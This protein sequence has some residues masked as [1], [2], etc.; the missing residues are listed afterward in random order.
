MSN[1]HQKFDVFDLEA[2]IERALKAL[3]RD[4]VFHLHTDDDRESFK[5]IVSSR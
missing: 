1:L 2:A 4:V 3:A 5:A